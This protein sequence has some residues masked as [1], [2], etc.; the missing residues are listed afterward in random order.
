MRYVEYKGIQT[1]YKSISPS[2][3]GVSDW[4]KDVVGAAGKAGIIT[5]NNTNGWAYTSSATRACVASMLSNLVEF[6]IN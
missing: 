3:T 6:Y 5:K 4:A 1:Q 2:M